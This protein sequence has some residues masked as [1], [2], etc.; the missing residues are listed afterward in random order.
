MRFPMQPMFLLYDN[1]E[2]AEKR[3]YTQST[4]P[5]KYIIAIIVFYCSGQMYNCLK[6]NHFGRK[7]TYC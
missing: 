4:V 1:I 7:K 3:D 6:M 5:L 2:M